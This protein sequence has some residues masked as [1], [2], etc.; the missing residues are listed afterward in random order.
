LPNWMILTMIER[1]FSKLVHNQCV[2]ALKG[3]QIGQ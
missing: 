1:P 2:I 3:R